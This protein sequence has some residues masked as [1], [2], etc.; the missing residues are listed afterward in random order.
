MGN[1]FIIKITTQGVYYQDFELTREE[2]WS[3][4]S[5]YKIDKEYLFLFRNSYLIM[6]LPIPTKQMTPHES[7]ELFQFVKSKFIEKK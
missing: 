7:G 5:E 6:A 2:K 3:I 1:N 4:F